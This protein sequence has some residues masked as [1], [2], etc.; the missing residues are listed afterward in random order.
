MALF[1]LIYH[2]ITFAGFCH[3]QWRQTQRLEKHLIELVTSYWC[4]PNGQYFLLCYCSAKKRYFLGK[5]SRHGKFPNQNR[6][7]Y[8]NIKRMK[9]RPSSYTH[10]ERKIRIIKSMSK[11]WAKITL[12]RNKI[13]LVSLF[14]QAPI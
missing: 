4:I 9:G 11:I 5:D 7:I 12:A 8:V 6:R 13:I 3:T 2:V 1:L 10:S 14:C